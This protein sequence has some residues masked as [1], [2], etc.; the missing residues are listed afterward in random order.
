M[1][2]LFEAKQKPL[3]VYNPADILMKYNMKPGDYVSIAYVADVLQ[4]ESSNPIR[5]GRMYN[6]NEETDSKLAEYIE[7]LPENSIKTLLTEFRNSAKYQALLNGTSKN[8]TGKLDLKAEHI[9]KISHLTCNWKDSKG[10]AK[11]YQKQQ[12]AELNLRRD[13][14]FEDGFDEPVDAERDEDDLT[15]R[16]K[17][18]YHGRNVY[19]RNPRKANGNVYKDATIIPGIYASL[20]DPSKVALRFAYNPSSSQKESEYYYVNGDGTL[21][22]LNRA[23]VTFLT[24]AYKEV[25]EETAEPLTG[26]EKE[27]VMKLKGIL[28]ESPS[29]AEVTLKCDSI[30]FLKSTARTQDTAEKVP[31]VWIN[32]KNV[33]NSYDFVDGAEFNSIIKKLVYSIDDTDVNG[34]IENINIKGKSISDLLNTKEDGSFDVDPAE[35]RARLGLSEALQNLLESYKVNR[36]KKSLYESIMNKL[37]KQIKRSIMNE[38]MLPELPDEIEV[39]IDDNVDPSLLKEIN[40]IFD[41]IDDDLLIIS[42]FEIC[43]HGTQ[44][45][46]LTKDDDGEI[47]FWA[48]NPYEDTKYVEQLI[49]TPTEKNR[50]LSEVV[51]YF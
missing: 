50:V 14:G 27:F 43:V 6:I 28:K 11:F 17:K 2:K 45:D 44:I 12:D 10:L 47:L 40:E 19:P 21:F 24:Y 29:I 8:K 48:G 22:P 36:I 31:F 49:L 18:E 16:D 7:E 46:C 13:Y 23:F 41:D 20:V 4:G 3:V 1:K 5:T 39:D 15:W 33:V 25:K 26:E 38:E 32:S 51:S 30:L 35:V 9:L 42:D 34:T 37:S